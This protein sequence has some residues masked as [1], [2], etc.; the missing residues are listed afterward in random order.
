MLLLGSMGT[1]PTTSHVSL[2]SVACGVGVPA[3]GPALYK[4]DPG[5]GARGLQGGGGRSEATVEVAST[6]NL[7][8]G[9]AT[10]DLRVRHQRHQRHQRHLVAE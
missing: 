2:P 8:P 6:T 4:K 1:S 5:K 9:N 3:G 10:T 7:L